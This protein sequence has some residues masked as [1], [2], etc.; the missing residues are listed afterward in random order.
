[1]LRPFALA[2]AADVQRLAGDA[3]VSGTT[4]NIP[5]PYP[6]GLAEEWIAGHAPAWAARTTVTF[7]VTQLGEL[8]GAIGLVLREKHQ[9]AEVG[10]WIGRPWWGQGL[11]TEALKALLAFAFERLQL[12]RVQATHLI[13][14]P[15]SGRVMQKAGM[16]LE[17]VHREMYLRNGRPEDVA[18]YAI[19]RREWSARNAQA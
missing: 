6:D 5:H 14:N 16:V 18:H 12:N 15:A 7:A 10:Y 19:L 1:M 17:G 9:R 2:D 4:L 11:A 8:R 13:R 3:Q